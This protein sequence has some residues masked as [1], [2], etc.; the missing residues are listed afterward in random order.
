MGTGS[1]VVPLGTVVVQG[2]PCMKS[3]SG[4]EMNSELGTKAEMNQSPI[5][6]KILWPLLS[7]RCC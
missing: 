3:P 4:L 1:V 2:N 7:V 5:T 6:A